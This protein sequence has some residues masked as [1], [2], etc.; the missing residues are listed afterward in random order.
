[1]FIINLREE[2]EGAVVDNLHSSR[3]SAQRGFL[4]LRFQNQITSGNERG[5]NRDYIRQ[6]DKDRSS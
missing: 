5:N 4:E 3:W 2:E 6:T 1:M